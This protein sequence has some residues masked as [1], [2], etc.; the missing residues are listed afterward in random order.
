MSLGGLL[1]ELRRRHVLRVAA[2]Y[3]AAAFAVLQAADLVFPML[4][5]PAW[6]VKFVLGLVL[7]GFPIALAL[8]W[9][10]EVTPEGVRRHAALDAEGA[11]VTAGPRWLV[12]AAVAL[13]AL[14]GW[15]LLQH[16]QGAAPTP[17]SAK[18]P[19]PSEPSIA[20][21]PFQNLSDS[22]D[23]EYFADGITEDILTQLAQLGGLL[24]TSRTSVM[25]YKESTLGLSEI[26]A[27]LGVEHVLEGSVR[28]D[29]KRVRVVAQLIE[30]RTDRHLWAQ[31]YD[32]ELEDVFAIQSEVAR[33]IASALEAR[34]RP[35][36]LERSMEAL[37]SS[38]EAYDLLLQARALWGTSYENTLRSQELARAAIEL[39]STYAAAYGWLSAGYTVMVEQ[40]GSPRELLD[41]AVALAE[42][43]I[44]L[45]K[46]GNEGLNTLGYAL[47]QQGRME[48]AYRASSRAAELNPSAGGVLS[49]MALLERER[50]DPVASLEWAF[51]GIRVDPRSGVHWNHVAVDYELIGDYGRAAAA[52]DRGR[53]VEPG[54]VWFDD[55]EVWLHQL[56]GRRSEA[57]DLARRRVERDPESVLARFTLLEAATAAGEWDLA[58]E[59]GERLLAMRPSQT[60]GEYR[61]NLAAAY[62]RLGQEVR[63]SALVD[64]V[65]AELR[66]ALSVGD[67]PALRLRLGT[68]LA[69]SGDTDAAFAAWE[70]ALRTGYESPDNMAF[71][72]TPDA[73]RSDPRFQALVRE[74]RTRQE[75]FRARVAALGPDPLP[76]GA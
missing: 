15:A 3:A 18:A 23:N 13:V 17:A 67:R 7:L 1:S 37:T 24:V 65:A 51:R 58:R 12:P 20:V 32:R 47:F 30:A 26:A 9:V 27:E 22:K 8:A 34:L 49:M 45:D 64:S 11:P 52:L 54:F 57:L 43:A 10:F 50:G 74:M 5:L 40:Y 55:N 19:G 2:L 60:Y 25:P 69:L 59:E 36:A 16:P 38:P 73:V 14:G 61:L 53:T 42:R 75:A 6:S 63:A 70:E 48:E 66:S 44:L 33:E 56:T 72:P 4:A 21:L 68:A 76:P 71:W 29:G 31:T 62:A 28:R 35:G 46:D 39:D 41:T